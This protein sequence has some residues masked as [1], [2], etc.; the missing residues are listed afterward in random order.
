MR[1]I[2]YFVCTCCVR[3][4]L[5]PSHGPFWGVGISP[6]CSKMCSKQLA[7][8]PRANLLK[9]L[10]VFQRAPIAATPVALQRPLLPDVCELVFPSVFFHDFQ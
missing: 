5:L 2:V 4:R 6:P 9:S 8:T 7:R 10:S 3:A 1:S